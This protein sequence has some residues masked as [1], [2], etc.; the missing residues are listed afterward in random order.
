ML[1]RRHRGWEL[2]DSEAAALDDLC[3]ADALAKMTEEFQKEKKKLAE[4]SV[5]TVLSD[6]AHDPAGALVAIDPRNGH[7]LAYVGGRGYDGP[8]PI[9][10]T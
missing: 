8:E 1:I 9:E 4:Q 5:A 7:V 10:I 3:A 6:R 2:R